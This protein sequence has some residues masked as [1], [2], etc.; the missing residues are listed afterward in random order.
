MRTQQ[1]S[2]SPAAGSTRR[3]STDGGVVHPL[4]PDP[5]PQGLLLLVH[6]RPITLTWSRLAST[7]VVYEES[8]LDNFVE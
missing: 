8:D 4:S 1:L 3:L 7:D 6:R 2:R 5:S